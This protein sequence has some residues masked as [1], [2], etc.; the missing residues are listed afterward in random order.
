[1]FPEVSEVPH[2]GCKKFSTRYG[3]DALK[4]VNG[5]GSKD[6]RLRGCFADVVEAE[7]IRIGDTIRKL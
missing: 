3:A 7:R 2:R 5:P 1:V 6:L 4:F